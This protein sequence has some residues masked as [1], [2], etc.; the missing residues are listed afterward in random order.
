MLEQTERPN[1]S[2]KAG[3]HWTFQR[4]P[5]T[6]NQLLRTHWA[7]RGRDLESWKYHV[8][9][10]AGNRHRLAK[11][12]RV[13]LRIVV[14][15]AKRQDPDNAFGSVKHLVDALNRLGWL[16]DDTLEWLELEV[17]EIVDRKNQRTEVHWEALSDGSPD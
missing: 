1:S 10:A 7:A 17:V 9:A 16:V 5:L 4:V 6:L 15:R 13:R 8:L 12:G 3:V 14:Y 2:E 11:R